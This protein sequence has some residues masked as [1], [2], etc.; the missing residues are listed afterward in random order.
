MEKKVFFNQTTQNVKQI[1]GKALRQASKHT[2]TTFT[3]VMS[4]KKRRK[5]QQQLTS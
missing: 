3:V 4:K 5:Q 2:N 1:F